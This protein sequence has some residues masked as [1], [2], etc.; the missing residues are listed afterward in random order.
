VL[1]R[2]PGPSPNARQPGGRCLRMQPTES[3]NTNPA[4]APRLPG[5]AP[6]HLASCMPACGHPGAA[7]RRRGA[8]LLGAGAGVTDRRVIGAGT[9]ARRDP[10][11]SERRERWLF[12]AALPTVAW[13]CRLLVG[14]I[15]HST[16]YGACQHQVIH[17]MRG[18]A[19]RS[20]LVLGEGAPPISR[21][22]LAGRGRAWW[23]ERTHSLRWWE[24][25][26]GGPWCGMRRSVTGM[27]QRRRT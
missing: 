12:F 3:G 26:A 8:L 10:D 24:A 27:E 6:H 7:S 14:L 2:L 13:T 4:P 15:R 22:S 25:T 17:L 19:T 23:T 20:M 1:S 21:L 9:V 5:T 16:R 11:R 18:P